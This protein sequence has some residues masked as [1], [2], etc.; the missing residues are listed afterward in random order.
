MAAVVIDTVIDA[1]CLALVIHSID[2]SLPLLLFVG[3]EIDCRL[4]ERAA[5]H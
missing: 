2:L 4:R 1:S 5:Y 3:V